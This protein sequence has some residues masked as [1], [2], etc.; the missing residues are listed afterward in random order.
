[1]RGCLD[2]AEEFGLPVQTHLAESA[3]K[4][5]AGLQRLGMTLTAHLERISC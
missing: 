4:R 3:V 5:A 2:L 1:M